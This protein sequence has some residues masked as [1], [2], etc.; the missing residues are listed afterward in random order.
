MYYGENGRPF[1]TPQQLRGRRVFDPEFGWITVDSS[2]LQ[3][4]VEESPKPEDNTMPKIPMI[5]VYVIKDMKDITEVLVDTSGKTQIFVEKEDNEDVNTI[6]LRQLVLKTG[7]TAFETYKRVIKEDSPSVEVTQD[8]ATAKE[9]SSTLPPSLMELLLSTV[10]NLN[11]KLDSIDG[12]LRLI[13]DE[14]RQDK[15]EKSNDKSSNNRK[16]SGNNAAG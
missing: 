3:S 10:E 6:H 5:P 16:S 1:Q 15:G 8:D 7:L 12:G 11:N 14:V 9:E 4:N 2:Y 13:M